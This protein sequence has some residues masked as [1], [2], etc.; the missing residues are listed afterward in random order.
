MLYEISVI[1]K[2]KN[3]QK[4]YEGVISADS[5]YE[6]IDYVKNTSQ[7]SEILNENHEI[8]ASPVAIK[9]VTFNDVSEYNENGQLF[10]KKYTRST[11]ISDEWTC[12]Y[13]TNESSCCKQCGEYNHDIDKCNNG[14]H[15]T[16]TDGIMQMMYEFGKNDKYS[17]DT[18][19]CKCMEIQIIE[20]NPSIYFT[21]MER[22]NS[23]PN[24]KSL[25]FIYALDAYG[26]S[27]KA[28]KAVTLDFVYSN[29]MS[30]V[31]DYCKQIQEYLIE[32]DIRDLNYLL[33]FS[34]QNKEV[35][36]FMKM[37]FEANYEFFN[38][39]CRKIMISAYN[40]NHYHY[41][42]ECLDIIS[43]IIKC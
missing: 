31:Y 18:E 12:E 30:Y 19:Y 6:A 40:K 16:T 33:I 43:D 42:R 5:S 8:K 20:G 25:W 9:S 7:L 13:G 23:K 26:Y 38:K 10:W 1:D 3:F 37:Y 28:T 4:V 21:M 2:S 17:I 24:K 29:Q 34:E 22:L 27:M 41:S 11:P 32:H 15:M 35:A 14:K 39:R 36:K